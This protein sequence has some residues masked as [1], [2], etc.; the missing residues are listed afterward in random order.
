MDSDSFDENYYSDGDETEED[1]SD[2]S[3][4]EMHLESK[5]EAYDRYMDMLLKRAR[6]IVGEEDGSEESEDDGE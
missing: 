3:E 6:D 5:K 1:E 4:V 2:Q